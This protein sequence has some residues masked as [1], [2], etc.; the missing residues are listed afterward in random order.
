MARNMGSVRSQRRE[1]EMT[2]GSSRSARR[3]MRGPEPGVGAAMRDLRGTSWRR[4]S[5][6]YGVST[7][8]ILRRIIVVWSLLLRLSVRRD[9]HDAVR[10]VRLTSALLDSKNT[11][12]G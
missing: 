9:L 4:N 2:G 11:V 7:G 8:L 3:L 1:E 12:L 6:L 5:S 10:T